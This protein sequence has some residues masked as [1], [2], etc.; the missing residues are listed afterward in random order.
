MDERFQNDRPIDEQPQS[1]EGTPLGVRIAIL[2]SA[3]M[4]PLTLMIAL[5]PG[6]RTRRLGTNCQHHSIEKQPAACIPG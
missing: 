4:I 3:L 1:A 6:R 2:G 5:K